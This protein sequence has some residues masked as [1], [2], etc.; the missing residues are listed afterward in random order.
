[1][2]TY[3]YS[4]QI[5][6]WQQT[7]ELILSKS[8][9]VNEWVDRSYIQEHEWLK[10]VCTIEKL[11]AAWVKTYTRCIPGAPFPTRWQLHQ[12]DYLLLYRLF[13]DYVNLRKSPR[14]HVTLSVSGELQAIF[15][16]W[17]WGAPLY[18]Q[19]EIIQLRRNSCPIIINIWPLMLKNNVSFCITQVSIQF[20]TTINLNA[21]VVFRS[22]KLSHSIS[23]RH[24]HLVTEKAT[25][26]HWNHHFF[27][28]LQRNQ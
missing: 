4:L 12:L 17:V 11:T 1:M 2:W 24:S 10:D 9:L 7:K 5:R 25:K 6:D 14:D 16:S 20:S 18:F 13:T 28:F 15:I 23:E 21:R 3:I 22:L 19:E 8:A 27:N 26:K